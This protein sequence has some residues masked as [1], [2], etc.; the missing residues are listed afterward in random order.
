VISPYT[1]TLERL[2]RC[3]GVRGSLVV[4]EGDGLI[5][6]ANLRI[7][8]RGDAVAALGASVYRRTRRAAAAARLGAPAFLQLD[9]ERGHVCVA[10]AGDLVV[11]VVT[12]P[13]ANIGLLRVEL[14]AAVRGLP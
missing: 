3:R 14:L 7:G 12:E 8:E 10:G 1:P 6:D 2:A 11:M 4:S 5:V 9:A 13:G